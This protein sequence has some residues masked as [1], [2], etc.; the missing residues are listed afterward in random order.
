[1]TSNTT[2]TSVR[3]SRCRKDTEEL[4]TYSLSIIA[5]PHN[6]RT[7]NYFQ[8][9]YNSYDLKFTETINK[10]KNSCL[11]P[12]QGCF[13]PIT[14]HYTHFGITRVLAIK[15]SQCMYMLLKMVIKNKAKMFLLSSAFQHCI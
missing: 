9:I 2:L 5:N 14:L 4:Q 12:I 13:I 1:M 6:I 11:I 8:I 10:C 3:R 7:R 15:T